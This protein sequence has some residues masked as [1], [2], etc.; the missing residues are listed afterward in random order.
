MRIPYRFDGAVSDDGRWIVWNSPERSLGSPGFNCSGFV[1]EAVRHL[2]GLDISLKDASFDRDGDSGEDSPLG[3]DWDF[4]LDLILNFAPASSLK[5]YPQS[6]KLSEGPSGRPIGWGADIH[7]EEF[8][9]ILRNLEKG[10]IHLIAISKPDRRFKGGLSY[11]HVAVIHPESDGRIWIYQATGRAGVHRIDLSNTGGIATIRRY[12]P[13]IAGGGRRAVIA[14]MN[15]ECIAAQAKQ[16][17][18]AMAKRAEEKAR[19]EE[20]TLAEEKALAEKAQ[21]AEIQAKEALA[22]EAQANEALAAAQSQPERAQAGDSATG[23]SAAG[24]SV[25]IQIGTERTQAS[26]TQVPQTQASQASAAGTQAPQ[27][28]AAQSQAGLSQAPAAPEGQAPASRAAGSAMTW[29]RTGVI[30]S[31]KSSPASAIEVPGTPGWNAS[32]RRERSLIEQ[33]AETPDSAIPEVAPPE[34]PKPQTARPDP[35]KPKTAKLEPSKPM[36]AKSSA[37]KPDSS[38][39]GSP[40]PEPLKPALPAESG[41]AMAE[42]SQSGHGAED[43]QSES[44]KAQEAQAQEVQTEEVQTA[45]AQA[46]DVQA[47]ELPND[48]IQ[49]DNVQTESLQAENMEAKDLRDEGLEASRQGA[50][51]Q[52][53]DLQ[54]ADLQDAD[55][56]N[57]GLPEANTQN[58]DSRDSDF[59]E[60]AIYAWPDP[61]DSGLPLLGPYENPWTAAARLAPNASPNEAQDGETTGIEAAGYGLGLVGSDFGADAP[62]IPID[63]GSQPSPGQRAASQNTDSQATIKQEAIAQETTAQKTTAQ[64]ATVRESA[65]QGAAAQ[66]AAEKPAARGDQARSSESPA[67][68]GALPS[69]ASSKPSKRASPKASQEVSQEASLGAQPIPSADSPEALPEAAA[70]KTS[71]PAA[72]ESGE[73]SEMEPVPADLG[74]Y[75]GLDSYQGYEDLESEELG[76]GIKI[77][78]LK[79]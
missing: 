63:S 79:P 11:Y 58:A 49:A 37:S 56:H 77:F 39:P 45:E 46:K 34:P 28:Q 24:E 27:T 71:A 23:E 3:A 74:Y 36:P 15:S 50:D 61:D 35:T 8:V 42:S 21:A 2:T 44:L 68:K 48:D 78:T 76:D 9:E 52:T 70:A 29:P 16:R 25:V 31:G 62:F 53:A 60:F 40:K 67:S 54:D 22:N 14:T 75:P 41:L 18:L 10:K 47:E 19:A 43:R 38:K 32:R 5:P 64:E 33:E 12:F 57:L 20:K 65:S 59:E 66:A 6:P 73:A 72:G 26:Q 55:S 30:S 69:Q 51:L 13:A 7:G 4:G 17:E 1:L